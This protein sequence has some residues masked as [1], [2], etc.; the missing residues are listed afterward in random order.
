MTIEDTSKDRSKMIITDKKVKYKIE[1][2]KVIFDRGFS[3]F[4]SLA[5]T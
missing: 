2:C 5:A 3:S 4:R 1:C